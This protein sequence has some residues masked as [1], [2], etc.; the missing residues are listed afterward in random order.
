MSD[1]PAGEQ[2]GHRLLERAFRTFGEAT[3]TIEASYR[4]LRARVDQLDLELTERN[5]ALRV[6]LQK[7]EEIRS[8]LDAVLESLSTGVLVADHSGVIVRCN[9]AAESL[10][11][12]PQRAMTGR[13]LEAVLSEQKL[14][15]NRYPLVTKTGACV[16]LARAVPRGENGPSVGTVVLLQDISA[17]RQLEERLHR[18]DR[19]ASMGEM[20]GGIAHEIRNPLGSVELFASMLRQDLAHDPVRRSYAEH[21][22]LAV[23]AMDRLLSNLLTYTKPAKP[24]RERHPPEALV[25]ETLMMAAHALA[26][27]KIDTVLRFES[28]PPTVWGDGVQLRQ[29]LLNL[30]LNAVEAMPQGGA[31]T[32]TVVAESEGPDSQPVVRFVVADTGKGIKSAHLSRLFDPFF[33]T[34]QE[35]TG[36]GLAIVHALVEGHRGRIEVSSR[37]KKGSVFTVTLPQDVE[38]SPIAVRRRGR[39]AHSHAGGGISNAS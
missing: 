27:A 29:I 21:I 17:V 11:G 16:S 7:T 13:A 24:R 22:S 9:Q 19:L 20:V 5:D 34:R 26:G 39:R 18:R 32:M 12:A 8:H 10:L 28:A 14:D 15:G 33:T 30:V 38:M 1:N 25:R 35:G 3:V 23:Q 4:A 37:V 36:L 6:N 31:L 2:N